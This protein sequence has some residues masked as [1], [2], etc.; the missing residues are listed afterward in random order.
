[1]CE[2]RVREGG[3]GQTFAS[4][5]GHKTLEASAVVGVFAVVV[6]KHLLGDV[7]VQ[8]ERLDRDV[9][10]TEG[11]LQETPEVLDTVC[12]DVT[13][14]VLVYVVDYFLFVGRGQEFVGRK[15]IGDDM[16]SSF[17]VRGDNGVKVRFLASVYNLRLDA[18]TALQHTHYNR[19]VALPLIL[20]TVLQAALVHVL[21]LATNEGFVALD[22][23]TRKLRRRVRHSHAN[24]VQQE[25][26][27]LLCDTQSAVN[28]VRANAVLAVGQHPH[29]RHPLIQTDRAIFHNRADFEGELLFATLAVPH[30]ASLDKGVLVGSTTR[31]SHFASSP[32]QVLRV[33]E[34]TVCVGE[35]DDGLLKC[36]RRFH[37]SNLVQIVLCVK[38]IITDK[39]FQNLA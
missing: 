27:R 15:F 19:L 9:S 25:P 26:S 30:F 4:N 28:L 29:C 34:A 12:V 24:T 39:S 10:T 33:V 20:P 21:D 11:A 32:A 23:A 6:T 8:V 16:R 36:M 22:R 1:V 37:S 14:D 17:D 35:E 2:S 13:V 5:R 31:A 38:Y 3:I 18:T 7:S